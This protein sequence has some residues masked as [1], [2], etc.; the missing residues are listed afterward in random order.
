MFF[1]YNKFVTVFFSS[2]KINGIVIITV[3]E[4][5][6]EGDDFIYEQNVINIIRAILQ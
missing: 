5:I 6:G 1:L 2:L 4:L 3:R